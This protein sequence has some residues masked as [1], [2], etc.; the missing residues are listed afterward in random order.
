LKTR[1][2][3][4][5]LVAV[6]MIVTMLPV[7]A[8]A[9]DAA[10]VAVPDASRIYA[11]DDKV[12]ADGEDEVT[13]TVHLRD[14]DGNVATGLAEGEKLYVWAE[15]SED[16]ISRIDTVV[17]PAAG[18]GVT[19]ENSLVAFSN[20]VG[21][22]EVKYTSKFDGEVKFWFAITNEEGIE[23]ILDDKADYVTVL[24]EEDE[25]YNLVAVEESMDNE[26]VKA[27]GI[28][29]YKVQFKVTD[30]FGFPVKG[31]KVNF[32]ASS[33]RLVL[34]K[35]SAVT[36]S[37]GIAEVKVST[38]RAGTYTVYAELDSNRK[39]EAETE[40]KFYPSSAYDISVKKGDG[41]VVA[42]DEE[43]T[44]EFEVYDIFG[45]L[46]KGA[47]NLDDV[48]DGENAYIDEV[49]V[50]DKPDDSDIE[51][52]DLELAWNDNENLKVTVPAN[53]LDEEG[54]Y[55]IRVRLQSGKHATAKFEVKE[56]GEIVAMTIEYD[57]DYSAA[58]DD[59]TS[60]PTVKV[61]DAE[62]IEANANFNDLEFSVSNTRIARIDTDGVVYARGDNE[63]VVTVTVVDTENNV[64]ATTEVR[65]G[66]VGAAGIKFDVPEELLV[67]EEYT[68]GMKVVDEEGYEYMNDAEYSVVVLSKPANAKVEVDVYD[69]ELVVYSDT[70][71]EVK[72]IVTARDDETNEAVSSTL[73]LKFVTEPIKA[74]AGKV[75]LTIGA[76]FGLV[77]GAVTELD[78][79]AFIEE[80]RTF[81][82]V[83]FLAEA[84]GAEA[85]WTP[86]DAPVETVT[87]T[88]DDMEIVIG[89]GDEFL[90]VTKDGEAEVM[91][92][93]GAARI[94]EGRTYLPFRA[95]AEAFGAEVDYGTDAEGYVTWVSFE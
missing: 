22:V 6:A 50:A 39:K 32:D 66:D 78:A 19:V 30:G 93:D 29:T 73:T 60:E 36:N 59:P 13:I 80:G 34:N 74:V 94:K 55:A 18:D 2:L 1:K 28:D 15:R 65:I 54:D 84:F 16:R 62:G 23:D 31:Q 7:V 42:L 56:Q 45:R 11:S 70:K 63:G 72:L 17:S 33:S 35:D 49:T 52:E 47:I 48:D 58:D 88:T 76:N 4:A 69:D 37:A 79:P 25:G 53:C 95:I 46:I 12:D 71:G 38:E 87:L 92:F 40:V 68:I 83:R 75:V 61:I 44:F 77:D 64:V 81:V 3:L 21:E 90:T 57:K 89:I 27:N 9:D 67:D 8:F 26:D 51:D 14:S 43:Y 10:G 41:A 24:F 20:A 85:D 82:P 5:M 91:T 86:K